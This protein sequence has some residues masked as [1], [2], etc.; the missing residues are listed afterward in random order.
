M[1]DAELKHGRLAMLA[2][3][4][5]P[6]A[7]LAQPSLASTFHAP[8]LVFKQGARAV[9]VCSTPVEKARAS[10]RSRNTK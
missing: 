2:A 10:R 7:E 3:V 8:S 4:G 9:S 1:R 6:L 5:W